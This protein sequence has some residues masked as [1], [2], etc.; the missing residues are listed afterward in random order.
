MRRK[1]KKVAGSSLRQQLESKACDNGSL[2]GKVQAASLCYLGVFEIK[3]MTG[4]GDC[5]A[6]LYGSITKYHL[7][8]LEAFPCDLTCERGTDGKV[9][10]WL[11]GGMDMT[12]SLWLQASSNWSKYC[13]MRILN[14][15]RQS[16]TPASCSFENLGMR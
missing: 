16:V 1:G 13:S 9:R 15:L 11:P 7:V 14:G 12:F 5:K 10:A 4:E 6:A 3:S 2:F 8:P